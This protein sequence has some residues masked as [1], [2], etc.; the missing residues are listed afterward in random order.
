[1]SST[2]PGTAPSSPAVHTESLVD[3]P[4]DPCQISFRETRAA[5][6]DRSAT[7]PN[8]F[9][10]PD[11]WMIDMKRTIVMGL[12]TLGLAI[13]TKAQWTQLGD[14]TAVDVRAASILLTCGD[15]R[16]RIDAMNDRVLRVRLAPGGEFERDFSWAVVDTQPAGEFTDVKQDDDQIT[17]LISGL[18]VIVSRRPCRIEVR[19]QD[20][21]VL[22]ADESARGMG[23]Q[24]KPTP[25]AEGKLPSLRSVRV[26]QTF[27][28]NTA[29]YGMGEKTGRLNKSGQ[30]WAMWNSDVPGYAA[31]Q[32]PLYESFPF[33]IGSRNNR[34]W[35]V[36][37]DNCHRTSFDFGHAERNVLTFGAESGELDYYVIA[38]PGPKDVVNRYTDLTGR[39]PLPPKWAIG[40]QQCRYSYY[41]ESRIREIA[42]TFRK[43]Q[44]PC[45][46]IYFDIDYMDGFR[47]FTWNP[48]WFPDP[49]G[50]IDDLHADGFHTVAIIDPGIKHEP[51]YFVFDQGD[52]INAWLTRPD[53]EAYIGR[54]WPGDSVFPD[55][56]N[57]K[58]RDWWSGLFVKFLNDCHIDGIWND[59]NEPADFVGP[60]H[61]VPLDTRFDNAGAPASHHAC[62][63]VYGMQM[64]RATYEGI[65]RARPGERAYTLTRATYAGGQRFG[66]AW[67]G[68]N[69][70]SWQ[71]LRMSVP[72]ALN[73][74]VSGMPV[75]G[76]DIGGFVGGAT[77]RLFA[78]WIQMCSLFPYSRA[79]T[80]WPSPD[81]EPWSYGPEVEEISRTSLERRYQ[82]LPYLYTLFE[83]A[84]RTG[85]P[86]LR[87]L[88]MEFPGHWHWNQDYS[89]MLG[90]DVYVAPITQPNPR[91]YDMWLPPGAWYDM[92]TGD[93]H[94][95]GQPVP[96]STELNVLPIFAR[97]GAII[98]MQSVVQHTGATPDEPL[99]VDIWLG[100][101]G[102]AELY[103]DDGRTL[104]YQSGGFART[105]MRVKRDGDLIV[106]GMHRLDG[107]YQPPKRSPLL[108]IHGLTRAIDD[109]TILSKDGEAKRSSPSPDAIPSGTGEFTHDKNAATW[110]VRLAPD[111]GTLQGARIRLAPSDNAP[112]K[113]VV[114]DF[115]DVADVAFRSDLLAPM[116]ENGALKL[117]VQN[118][119]NVYVVLKRV[120]V[121]AHQL[122]MIRLKL[123]TDTTKKI[124]IRFATSQSP[125]LSKERLITLDVTANGDIHEYVIDAAKLTEG[126]WDGG[127]Y[128]L[129]LDFIEGMSAGETIVLDSVSFEPRS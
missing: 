108:R 80:A 14:V 41:P 43:K 77:P 45:D 121:P 11:R 119:G 101:E 76:P 1:M 128:F 98:P 126:K 31:D 18:K 54:V 118:T 90:A 62:H 68:D 123:A 78:R 36:F 47:C 114:I 55:F 5:I 100:D 56:T 107:D 96:V 52:K 125:M 53:G 113:P 33:F 115:E 73:L 50:L 30:T 8:K 25:V 26:W 72:M 2:T 23:W 28:A 81:Q 60:N 66:A 34:Y 37:L 40:Y 15:D 48:K 61:T 83:E 58:V 85:T 20:D 21:H 24:T 103:E 127:V 110:L 106:F 92:N 67:T 44:I 57:P 3:T 120:N 116:R 74:G 12:L 82:L 35:G 22:L 87:P 71:H 122:P 112:Q 93:I 89:F 17:A 63:N 102:V 97:A 91:D 99:I 105:Q 88:W 51:G 19:D 104:D 10:F 27:D 95:A 124:G 42:A 111:D 6:G 39:T 84:S 49:A 7:L 32:D 129:R 16:V 29:I 86:I 109:V 69:V 65:R 38:G 46:V 79:H 117:R 59:M 94:A 64:H 13:Q 70:S 9:I 4:A 75:I